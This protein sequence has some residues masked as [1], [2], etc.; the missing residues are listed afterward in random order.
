MDEIILEFILSIYTDNASRL[1]LQGAKNEVYI[2]S[3]C[4]VIS[5]LY[6]NKWKAWWVNI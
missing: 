6:R 4:V 1:K 2:L 3:S 5:W